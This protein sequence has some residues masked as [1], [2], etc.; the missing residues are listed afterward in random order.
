[1]RV[2]LKVG[3]SGVGRGAPQLH[4]FSR[5]CVCGGGFTTSTENQTRLLSMV[6]LFRNNLE[7]KQVDPLGHMG[8][9]L[10][11]SI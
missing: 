5:V 11:D 3:Y 2:S 7:E 9:A 8:L 1:M 6:G 4:V 10:N